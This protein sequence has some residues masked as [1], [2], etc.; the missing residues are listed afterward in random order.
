MK[1]NSEQNPNVESQAGIL[2]MQCCVQPGIDIYH[3]DNAVVMPLLDNESIDVICIDPPYLYL[4]GQKLERQF[5]EKKF[6]TECKRLLKRD[7]F[8]IMFGRGESFY[9]W[10]S[11]LLELGFS[12]K[13]EIIWDKSHC[14]SPLMNITRVH[15]TISIMTKGKG[16]INKSKIPYLEMKSNDVG[17]IVQ[18]IKRL[19]SIFTQA[20]SMKAVLDF[21]ENNCKR[22]D[23]KTEK[24]M[25][26]KS[27]LRN[28]KCN[29]GDRCVTVVNSIE[30]GLNEKS[31]IRNYTDEVPLKHNA[32]SREGILERDRCEK[33][34]QSVEFGLTEKTIIKEI[35]EHYTAIHPTQKP[36]RLLERLLAL[37]SNKDSV[38]AD[39]FAGSMST[40][41]AVYNMR[42]KGIAVEID[43]EYFEDG[44]KRLMSL[45]PR[46][47][48]LFD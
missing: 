4:K 46:Q 39:F 14:T 24:Q 38:V 25:D 2:P 22:I 29:E 41:E 31:I 23:F 17:S 40:M 42:L 20:K 30:N 26:N 8:V 35:R 19:R 47:C 37:V 43:E 7:G 44:K 33:V 27:N 18:D 3:A 11:I 32:N 21:L 36:V 9:R 16:T 15:E 6:F 1:L 34:V 48:S 10:N 5:D 12:F 45:P 28:G 13:E